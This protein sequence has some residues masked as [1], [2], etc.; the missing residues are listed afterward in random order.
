MLKI[1]HR[2]S[3]VV[4]VLLCLCLASCDSGRKDPGDM[5][6][7]VLRESSRNPE[8]A[9]NAYTQ[10]G[11][12][13]RTALIRVFFDIEPEGETYYQKNLDLGFEDR[14]FDRFLE[15]L[16]EDKD[17]LRAILDASDARPRD[18]LTS[19]GTK[20]RANRPRPIHDTYIRPNEMEW[21]LTRDDGIYSSWIS[22]LPEEDPRFRLAWK[23]Y[24]EHHPNKGVDTFLTMLSRLPAET[25]IGDSRDLRETIQRFTPATLTPEQQRV[26][27]TNRLHNRL[28]SSWKPDPKVWLLAFPEDLGLALWRDEQAVHPLKFTI[29]WEGLR[30]ATVTPERG[31]ALVLFSDPDSDPVVSADLMRATLTRESAAES[32]YRY[33]R[34]I[35]VTLSRVDRVRYTVKDNF[36]NPSQ[37]SGVRSD[38]TASCID[39]QTGKQLWS[40]TFQGG[41]PPE[42][43]FFPSGGVRYVSGSLPWEEAHN[44]IQKCATQ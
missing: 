42:E 7:V 20:A 30:K 26:I 13:G 38:L 36:N 43:T 33:D 27:F 14:N 22:G 17:F 18:P 9:M 41:E 3:A 10:S 40:N 34:R 6:K 32:L 31:K 24:F 2:L 23:L 16:S 21:V 28:L 35:E 25:T 39:V 8:K 5:L 29:P 1:L 15:K 4:F 44:A 12:E 19:A 37:L 11:P